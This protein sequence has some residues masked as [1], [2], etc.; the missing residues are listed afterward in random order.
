[1]L[2][3]QAKNVLRRLLPA[4]TVSR[5]SRVSRT[6]DG[7]IAAILGG[8]LRALPIRVR[9]LTSERLSSSTG[10]LDYPGGGIDIAVNSEAELTRLRP[11][12]KEPETVAWIERFVQPGDVVF[13]VGANVGAYS[14]IADRAAGG[15][16]RIYAF[17]PSF[18][19]FAQLS[20]NVALN[21]S[22]GRVLPLLI[23]L[24]DTNGLIT[25]NYS[26]LHPGA[27][28]HALGEPVD[29]LGRPFQAALSQPVLSYRMDDFIAQ[30]GVP[31]PNH[32]KLDVDGVELKVLRGAPGVLAHPG[33]RT[34]LV[35]V[36]PARPEPGEIESLL[37]RSGFVVEG[38]YPHGPSADST[39]NLLFTRPAAE[40]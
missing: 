12:F 2:A 34:V 28:M 38:R 15:Q 16:C 32:I 3:R 9:A 19:T 8:G 36:E 1:M 13:D 30:F 17:E 20:R 22:A 23:A 24:S 11:C 14:L 39:T 4:A 27:A 26:S 35:E 10:R 31:S 40:R 6:V 7:T 25:F 29:S 18:S 5:L 37:A 33:L 21:G